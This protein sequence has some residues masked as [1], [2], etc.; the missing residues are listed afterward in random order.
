[1][2]TATPSR[3]RYQNVYPGTPLTEKRRLKGL[4]H[5]NEWWCMFSLTSFIPSLATHLILLPIFYT[6]SASAHQL[7]IPSSPSIPPNL[8][9]IGQNQL[10]HTLWRPGNCSP[11]KRAVE[12]RVTSDTPNRGKCFWACP[13]PPPDGCGFFLFSEE[14]RVREVGLTPSS[15]EAADA[16]PAATQSKSPSLTQMRLTDIGIQFLGGRRQSDPGTTQLEDEDD[17]A[18]AATRLQP[19]SSSQPEAGA[20]SDKGKGKAVT[21]ADPNYAPLTPGN[22]GGVKRSRDAFEEDFDDIGSDEEQQLAV[23]TDRSVEK[24]IREHGYKDTE[25]GDDDAL[26]TSSR[27][28]ARTLFPKA[29]GSKRQKS[30]SFEEPEPFPPTPSRTAHSNST[31]PPPQ[32]TMQTSPPSSMD[33]PS[34]PWSSMSA[35]QREDDEGKD[36]SN[37]DITEQV[38]GLLQTQSIDPSVLESVHS[39][40]LTS[41]RRTKGIAM[42]RDSA[43]TAINEKKMKIARLQ[44]RVVALENKEQSLN[45]QI[46]HIKASLMKMYEDN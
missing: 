38:M 8:L 20:S 34:V 15:G 16:P 26:A 25:D 10:T 24:F 13:Y 32:S 5:R 41:A 39:L 43:R 6:L 42:G 40:L 1:M 17:N 2:A 12:R 27:P 14:A 19:M 44:E 30:V 18:E 29:E 46:T 37:T 22:T 9:E 21:E 31:Q 33:A 3:N 23:M 7:S 11:R 4:W 28:V 45:S 35:T 36:G